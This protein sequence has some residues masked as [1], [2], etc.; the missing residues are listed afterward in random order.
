MSTKFYLTDGG[1][2]PTDLANPD[3]LTK[4]KEIVTLIRES[5]NDKGGTSTSSILLK[6]LENVQEVNSLTANFSLGKIPMN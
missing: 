2:I 6:Q 5:L 4:F 3:G 1:E